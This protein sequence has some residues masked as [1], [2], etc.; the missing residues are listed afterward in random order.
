MWSTFAVK[1]LHYDI[2]YSCYRSQTKLREE[3]VLHPS[4]ILSTKGRSL[5]FG[6]RPPG[7]KPPVQRIPP[8][9]DI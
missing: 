1:T 3:Y 9:T 7:Q 4:L 6:Q 2:A 8:R 5:P